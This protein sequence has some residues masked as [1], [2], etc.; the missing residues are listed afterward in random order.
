MEQ[1]QGG[2]GTGSGRFEQAQGADIY[3]GGKIGG[4]VGGAGPGCCFFFFCSCAF[5]LAAFSAAT[6]S[7]SRPFEYTAYTIPN[8]E[9][10]EPGLG[11]QPM[12]PYFGTL[13]L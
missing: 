4:K 9:I 7:G 10:H 6:T 8:S 5:F 1:A 3:R 11:D 12:N 13:S 2:H